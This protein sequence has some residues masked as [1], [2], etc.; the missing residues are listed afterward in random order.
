MKYFLSTLLLLGLSFSATAMQVSPLGQTISPNKNNGSMTITN[1]SKDKKEYQLKA[2]K[3]TLVNGKQVKEAVDEIRF[4]PSA[5]FLEPGKSQTVRFINSTKSNDELAYRVVATEKSAAKLDRSGVN[6]IFNMNFP[7]F[8]RAS[9][10]AELKATLSQ[11]QIT[12]RNNGKLTAQLADFNYGTFK[13][14]GLY[15]YLLP[16]EELTLPRNDASSIKALVNS[17]P[18]EILVEQ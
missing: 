4:A 8:W 14:P 10:K 5:F 12:L 11:G 9:N 2:F 16:G 17:S 7:I 15:L 18:S 1:V 6:P 13:K 3:W